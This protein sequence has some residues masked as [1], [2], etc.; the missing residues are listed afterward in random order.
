[1]TDDRRLFLREWRLMRRG[2]YLIVVLCLLNVLITSPLA[3]TA[4]PRLTRFELD[5]AALRGPEPPLKAAVV[6]DPVSGRVLW[7]YRPQVVLPIAS[8]TKMMVAL[9]V[10]EK[11]RAGRLGWKDRVTVSVRAR[12]MG[13]RQVFLQEGEVFT[14]RELFRAMMIHSANDAAVALA[15]KAAGSVERFVG[16][17]NARARLLKMTHTTFHHVHGLPPSRGQEA[18]QSCA[19]DMAR[20]AARLVTYPE[21]LAVTSLKQAPFRSGTFVLRNPNK[22][23]YRYPGAD[24]L[25]TGYHRGAKFC[26]A[27]TAVKNGRRLVVVV[28]GSINRW[29]RFRQAGWL[30]N[31]GFRKLGPS[32]GLAGRRPWPRP[33]PVSHPADQSA[34]SIGPR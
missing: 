24:G 13:G 34:P 14:V 7:A 9:V 6:L 26:V 11:I 5:L 4:K 12:K 33:I 28:L 16:L 30:L 3:A 27:G 17:M 29:K 21:V 25:K 32:S 1:M 8:L 22:L 10:L 2:I 31:V 19:L 15:E 20:L 23:L 18:D